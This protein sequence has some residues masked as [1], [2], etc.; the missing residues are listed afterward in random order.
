MYLDIEWFTKQDEKLQKAATTVDGVEAVVT[1]S[2][3]D[4][5]ALAISEKLGHDVANILISY[6]HLRTTIFS[7]VSS[8]GVTSVAAETI[9]QYLRESGVE[10]ETLEICQV[11]NAILVHPRLVHSRLALVSL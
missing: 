8:Y 1:L 5:N 7:V 3:D 4:T 2:A 9:M 11:G 6:S 10:S